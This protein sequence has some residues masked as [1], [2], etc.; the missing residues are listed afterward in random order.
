MTHECNTQEE[1][2]IAVTSD[3]S[4]TLEGNITSRNNSLMD[5]FNSLKD[6]VIKRLQEDNTR[7]GQN[8]IVWQK[9]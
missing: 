9:Y 2:N 8:V 3:S 5:A 1:N 4:K 7:F 6:V